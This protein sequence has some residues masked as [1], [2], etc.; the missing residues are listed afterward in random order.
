MS[1]L[2]TVLIMSEST[3]MYLL[4]IELLSRNQNPVPITQLAE[5]LGVS[6]ISAN[7]MCRKL[8]SRDLVAYQP[9]KGVTLTEQGEAIAQRVL[10]K[11]HL[12]E[13]FLTD[14]LGLDATAA[15][16]IACRLEH[17]T[18]DELVEQLSAFLGRPDL[19]PHQP[20]R[21]PLLAL[22][23][24]QQARVAAICSEESLA[25][26][27]YAQQ[28]TPGAEIT[29]LARSASQTLLIQI[30]TQH[31]TLSAELAQCVDVIPIS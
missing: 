4:H 2:K 13:F 28:L 19:T 14:K 31:L 22:S 26:F 25:T 27:L 9:Y 20:P 16:E 1:L 7:Q 29:L 21:Q 11:R 3:E 5:T 24:G 23:V 10:R 15:E 6:P 8:E 30:N 12:W 17:A 18:P